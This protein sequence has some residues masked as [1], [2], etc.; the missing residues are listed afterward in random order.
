MSQAILWRK[1]KEHKVQCM[2]CSHF[3]LIEP[4]EKG[5]CG[6]RQNMEGILHSLVRDKLAALNLDPI[7]KKPLFHFLPGT[8]TLSL[9]TMGCN[10]SCTFCQNYSLSQPPKENQELE[11]ES[12]SPEKIVEMALE[13][14]AA[15]ISYTY[16]EPTIFIE[17]VMDTARLAHKKGLKNIIVSNGYQSPDCLQ[18]M[19]GFID[20][21]NIDLKAFT[22]SFYK[23]YCG[24]RLKPVQNNLVTI[25][26]MG[27]WL[28]VTTLIIPGLNDSPDELTRLADFLCHDL[29][30]DTPWHISR[31]HPTFKMT[32]RPSTPVETLEMACAIGK[33]AGLEHVYTGNVP[34]HRSESTFCP[35]C[36]KEVITRM[37]FQIKKIELENRACPDC[38]RWIPGIWE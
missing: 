28:E 5:L 25:K 13:Y 27:W 16:S 23:N 17:L 38:K 32:D 14:K 33:K 19:D 12:I 18:E 22:D 1:Q 31:F 10:L 37:G 8:L 6:V 26:K 29:G 36:Q 35:D 3:C 4:G 21:A 7:E 11:G 20:A 30:P 9:G 24:A 34:G 15:S 2:A